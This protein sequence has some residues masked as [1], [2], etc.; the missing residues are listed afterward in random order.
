MALTKIS[1]LQRTL[2]TFLLSITPA[3]ALPLPWGL[4]LCR[5]R[6]PKDQ[7]QLSLVSTGC[8]NDAPPAQ[9][10]VLRLRKLSHA[11]WLLREQCRL[12]GVWPWQPPNGGRF[13]WA[14]LA[15]PW[16]PG[17]RSLL[18]LAQAAGWEA[19][20]FLLFFILLLFLTFPFSGKITWRHSEWM[21]E[22]WSYKHG[23]GIKF[24]KGIHKGGSFCTICFLR[25]RIM[26]QMS[27]YLILQGLE[28]SRFAINIG[29]T[30]LRRDFPAGPA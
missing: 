23:G 9:P 1:P 11:A 17:Q 22:V 8:I 25:V 5:L 7:N 30:I 16:K 14:R 24:E 28:H 6:Q 3:C 4:S 10:D 13:A 2:G 26:S 19:S 20:L 27:F 18:E 15:P 21:F 29:S 12:C